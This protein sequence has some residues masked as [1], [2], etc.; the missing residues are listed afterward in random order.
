MVRT[1]V[2]VEDR[3]NRL[4]RFA[5][6]LPDA[7][8][9]AGPG[10]DFLLIGAHSRARRHHGT[11]RADFRERYASCENFAELRNRLETVQGEKV[12]LLDIELPGVHVRRKTGEQSAWL[13][14]DYIEMLKNDPGM[15]LLLY[16]GSIWVKENLRFLIENG[17]PRDRVRACQEHSGLRG[18]KPEKIILDGLDLAYGSPLEDQGVRHYLGQVLLNGLPREA[19]LSKWGEVAGSHYRE[20][21]AEWLSSPWVLEMLKEQLEKAGR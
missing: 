12:I 17:A 21:C 10:D 6:V 3:E 16:S 4:R 20:G 2:A 9:G 1:I 15:S 13:P 11:L 5:S 14:T 18:G 19:F 8:A 7:L